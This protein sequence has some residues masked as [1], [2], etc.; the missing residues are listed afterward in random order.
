ME[1]T[2]EFLNI[3]DVVGNVLTMDP[4]LRRVGK[5]RSRSLRVPTVKYSWGPYN[6]PRDLVP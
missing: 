5:D 1:S 3:D 2:K 4:A 6:V